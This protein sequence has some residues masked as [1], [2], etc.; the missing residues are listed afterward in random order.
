MAAHRAA[1]AWYE[2]EG[3]EEEE[4]EAADELKECL[5]AAGSAV[6]TGLA[7]LMSS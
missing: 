1:A 2:E 7:R 3:E 5:D 6:D 4:R